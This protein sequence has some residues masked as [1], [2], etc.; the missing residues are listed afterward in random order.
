M[1]DG[2]C[3]RCGKLTQM[4]ME[5]AKVKSGEQVDLICHSCYFKYYSEAAKRDAKLDKILNNSIWDKLKRF[6]IE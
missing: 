2:G 6:I 5:P 1:I 4:I 3:Q